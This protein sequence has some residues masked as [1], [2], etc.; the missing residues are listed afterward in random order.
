MASL[1]ISY[2]R[3]DVEAARRL[4]DAFKGQ[5]LDYWID[6]EGIPPIVD[7]W[8]EIEK[9]IEEAD[10]FLFL[11]SPDSIKSK[12]CKQEIDHAVKNAKRL[13]PVVVRDTTAQEASAELSHLNWIFLRESDDF[14]LAL[15]KL[16]T[17]IKTDYEWVQVHRQLQ[18]KALE[19]ERS[20]RESSFLLT[21]KELREAEFQLATNTSK[22]PHP[23]DLQREYVFKSRQASDQRRRRARGVA[24]G[25]IIAL[26]G[27]AVVA[28]VQAG[29]ATTN[30]K[31][32]QAASTLA[33]SNAKTAEASAAEAQKQTAIAL[34]RELAATSITSLDLDS[35]LSL[36]LAMQSIKP[37]TL[38]GED[39]LRRAVLPVPVKLTLHGH[40]GAVYSVAYD[41]DGKRLVTASA[42]KTVRIWDA[43]T[44]RQLMVLRGHTGAVYRAVFSPDGQLV[45]TAS[46]DKTVRIWEAATGKQI[47]SINGH[48]AA[49]NSVAFSPDGKSLLTASDDTTARLWQVASGKELHALDNDQTSVRSAV[50]SPDGRLIATG[51]YEGHL[52][53]WDALTGDLL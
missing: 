33:V 5:D 53:I 8:K 38:Q 31:A 40:S 29:R 42:D 35:E 32:A 24:V 26:A 45:A 17:A 16:V 37:Y 23:T 41:N 9:G 36:H 46:A 25:V 49:V 43:A 3:K 28:W 30:A 14:N 21:G 48:S 39:A 27:L 7:W 1:F 15:G 12:V 13:I 22:E 47:R 18:V 50:F 19:W 51:G 20:G 52:N 11:I 2:S 10:A 4:T 34:A 44:G 6:W